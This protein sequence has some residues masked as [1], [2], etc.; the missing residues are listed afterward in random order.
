MPGL[1]EIW[2]TGKP[3]SIDG[4][5]VATSHVLAPFSET[6]RRRQIRV[7]NGSDAVG[8][9]LMRL[10]NGARARF[11]SLPDGARIMDGTVE[12]KLGDSLQL[13]A[14]KQ[15]LLVVATDSQAKYRSLRLVFR[16]D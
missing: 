9:Q 14:G 4:E 12:L 6:A 8:I 7:G 1:V 5:E 11:V 16:G 2:A 3:I 13:L 15:A 10:E